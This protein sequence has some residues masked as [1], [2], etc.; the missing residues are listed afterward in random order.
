MTDTFVRWKRLFLVLE[1]FVFAAC[2]YGISLRFIWPYD[3]GEHPHVMTVYRVLYP[4]LVP[5][6]YCFLAACGFLML[7]SPFFLRAL[8]SAAIRAWI[9]GALALV[10]AGCIWFIA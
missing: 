1:I 5:M 8:R 6:L 9:I 10:C 2:V 7:A 3:T 4:M